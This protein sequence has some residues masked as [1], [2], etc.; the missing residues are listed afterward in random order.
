MS[1]LLSSAFRCSHSHPSTISPSH[2]RQKKQKKSN[3][4][5]SIEKKGVENDPNLKEY[6]HALDHN[7]P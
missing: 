1:T 6:H 4:K 2:E 3:H 5:R 7:D